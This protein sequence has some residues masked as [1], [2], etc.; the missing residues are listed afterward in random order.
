MASTGQ[1]R[2]MLDVQTPPG[3]EVV[4]PEVG[5]RVESFSV[6]EN[7]SEPLQSL[8][9]GKTLHRMVW[10]LVPGLPGTTVFQ[11]LEIA[12]GSTTIRTAPFSVAVR[13]ILPEGVD[14]FK[15][16][17]IAAPAALLPEQQK[18]RHRWLVLAGILG[19]GV[20][21]ALAIALARR[22]RKT[23]VVPPHEA[24]FH[25]LENLPEE[26]LD[27]IH[28]LSEILMAFLGGR[29]DF[30]TL[31]KTVGEV[32]PMLPRKVLLGRRHKLEEFLSEA[33]QIRFSNRVPLGFAGDY[34][35][36]VREFIEEMKQEEVPCD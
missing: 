11:S 10:K 15:I 20:L 14:A 9:N 18:T 28:R 12:A 34:E 33:E 21:S 22:P 17:D 1:I 5:N 7:Y 36:Y 31:G 27:R 24:A 32:M 13:S 16:K 30:P 8:P 29:F 2:I 35:A 26:P 4:F 3:T 19:I 25:A 6:S 23:I